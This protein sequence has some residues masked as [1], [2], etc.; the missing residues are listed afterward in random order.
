MLFRL[1]SFNVIALA[2]SLPCVHIE[3]VN[4]YFA[5]LPYFVKCAHTAMCLYCNLLVALTSE[6]NS[7]IKVNILKEPE[8]RFVDFARTHL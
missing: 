7:N 4:G 5:L 3:I 6:G 8:P 1:S 2:V